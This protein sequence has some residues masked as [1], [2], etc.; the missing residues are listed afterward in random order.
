MH[1]TVV[2]GGVV[3]MLPVDCLSIAERSE[4]EFTPGGMHLMLLGPLDDLRTGDAVTLDF[5]YTLGDSDTQAMLSVRAP[6][7]A[8]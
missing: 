5:F 1:T 3:H 6:V 7:Q 8:R 4:I 2:E